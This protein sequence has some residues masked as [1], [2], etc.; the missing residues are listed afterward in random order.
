MP[1]F[2][3]RRRMMVD[4]Q[5]RPS[6]VTRYPIIEA[7]LSVPREQFVPQAQQEAAYVGENLNIAP[8]RTLLEPRTFAKMLEALPI[9]TQSRVLDLAVGYGYSSAVIARLAGSVVAVE[10]EGPLADQAEALL[11][12]S[13]RVRVLRNA[14][15]EGAPD[16][17]PFDVI[18]LQ[19]G[20]EAFPEALT[21]QLAEGGHAAVLFMEGALGVVRIGV[22]HQGVMRW[23]D[24]FNAAAPVV[25]GFTAVRS[26][27]L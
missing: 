9:D 12:T 2:A 13:D 25:E 11:A 22:K 3:S 14:P 10:A 8:G 23:R 20:A 15:A 16:A 7:I 19:G 1:D 26:F 4:T 5:V 21:A 24:L 17:A 18:L 6:D 27:A